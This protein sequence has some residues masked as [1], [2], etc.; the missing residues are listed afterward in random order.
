MYV[1]VIGRRCLKPGA[2]AFFRLTETNHTQ[3]STAA[4]ES[5]RRILGFILGENHLIEDQLVV[6]GVR[7]A[8]LLKAV[9]E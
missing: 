2:S 8:A 4:S 6:G 9:G 5:V 1:S 7:L 3:V